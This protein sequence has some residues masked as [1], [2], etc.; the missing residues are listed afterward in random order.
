[1]IDNKMLFGPPCSL[2][3]LLNPSQTLIIAGQGCGA[4]GTMDARA[5]MV[6]AAATV[7]SWAAPA[8]SRSA[9]N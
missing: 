1:M 3:V 7:L 5:H 9:C 6:L 4:G 2:C 8:S